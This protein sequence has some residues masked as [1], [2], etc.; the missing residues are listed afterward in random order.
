MIKNYMGGSLRIIII[1]GNSMF[2]ENI[3]RY[4]HSDIILTFI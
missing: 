1:F 4:L 2:L 3:Q